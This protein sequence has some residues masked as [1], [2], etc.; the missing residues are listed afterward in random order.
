MSLSPITKSHSKVN[1]SQSGD[2][3]AILSFHRVLDKNNVD[4][5]FK[6]DD[7]EGDTLKACVLVHSTNK[8]FCNEA[9]VDNSEDVTE[10]W[11]SVH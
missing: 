4:Y 1:S 7:K 10:M 3:R 5:D 9:R 11:V 2:E 8:R 6:I